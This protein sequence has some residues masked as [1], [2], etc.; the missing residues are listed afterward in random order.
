[1]YK[2]TE[3]K[4]YESIM[5]PDQLFKS[6]RNNA[7]DS[8]FSASIPTKVHHLYSS[9]KAPFVNNGVDLLSLTDTN[10]EDEFGQSYSSIGLEVRTLRKALNLP[11]DTLPK[12]CG[13]TSNHWPN[14]HASRTSQMFLTDSGYSSKTNP[15]SDEAV[16]SVTA[17]RNGNAANYSAALGLESPFDVKSS[18]VSME[19]NSKEHH[20]NSS[21]MY[22]RSLK[23][24]LDESETKRMLL[25]E[26]LREAHLAIQNQAEKLAATE[27][28]ICFL[29]GQLKSMG[30]EL[31]GLQQELDSLTMEKKRLEVFKSENLK[32]REAILIRVDDLDKEL[33]VLTATHNALKLEA[34]KKGATLEETTFYLTTLKQDN[35]KLQEVNNGL[36]KELSSLRDIVYQHSKSNTKTELLNKDY[37]KILQENAVIKHQLSEGVKATEEL[38]RKQDEMGQEI[39]QLRMERDIQYGKVSVLEEEILH[40]QRNY[41]N[42]VNEQERLLKEKAEQDH[43]LQRE[44]QDRLC[45]KMV[46]DLL[47]E[48]SSNVKE[49]FQKLEEFT[50]SV[51]QRSKDMSLELDQCRPENPTGNIEEVVNEKSQNGRLL[52]KIESAES[53]CENLRSQVASL[54]ET[55]RILNKETEEKE[56]QLQLMKM[57]EETLTKL[58]VSKCKELKTENETL[59]HSLTMI[60]K[61][62]EELQKQLEHQKEEM[63]LLKNQLKDLSASAAESNGDQSASIH[64][65]QEEVDKIKETVTRLESEKTVLISELNK[66]CKEKEVWA[67]QRS[68]LEMTQAELSS[69][70]TQLRSELNSKLAVKN[71]ENQ[72]IASV[73]KK[74]E[75]EKEEAVKKVKDEMK[76]PFD[77]VCLELK[78]VKSELSKVWDMLEIKE[79]ELEEQSQELQHEREQSQTW[80][81]EL[82][83]LRKDYADLTANTSSR[84]QMI[85]TLRDELTQRCDEIIELEAALSSLNQQKCNSLKTSTVKNKTHELKRR[86]SDGDINKIREYPGNS[87]SKCSE[88]SK[89]TA[90]NAHLSRRVDELTVERDSALQDSQD[91]LSGMQQLREAFEE[92]I[93]RELERERTK[94]EKENHLL[95]AQS[96]DGQ[97]LSGAK[98]KLEMEVTRLTAQK[99]ALEVKSKN[100]ECERDELRNQVEELCRMRTAAEEKAVQVDSALS[101]RRRENKTS[102][103]MR[104]KS[105]G[106]MSPSIQEMPNSLSQQ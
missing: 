39:I 10:L 40:R 42:L 67:I 52:L 70:N 3:G 26:K 97:Q 87:H 62:N 15:Q 41:N 73:K 79:K 105:V 20:Q 94:F 57:R 46:N 21:K 31:E 24:S 82:M 85:S 35:D 89:L 27:S 58:Q 99:V 80:A 12:T 96:G 23:S 65:L 60:S 18:P 17:S 102:L 22:E 51:E 37:K 2:D 13:L 19:L 28:E 34:S 8:R 30:I 4:W 33:K 71:T 5:N 16:Q 64:F 56:K 45:L 7:L 53:H 101:P 36:E 95:Q 50:N 59:K 61:K 32:N 47:R 74:L 44:I 25:L 93:E 78:T 69:E 43:R 14:E 86:S 106:M 11:V 84:S 55:N 76:E 100:L 92:E 77:E 81:E 75:L 6:S 29:R 54:Q 98:P 72:S 88:V 38:K 104:S 63:E 83:K 68:E 49:A 1:M 9:S 48:E 103:R 90:R 91:L 66:L